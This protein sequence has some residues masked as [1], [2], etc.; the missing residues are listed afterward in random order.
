MR[1]FLNIIKRDLLL[2]FKQSSRIVSLLMFFVISVALFPFGVGSDIDLLAKI[3]VGV[4]WVCALLSS[5]V[6]ISTIFEDDYNDGSLQQFILTG[7][8]KET[9]VIAKI[10]AH[11]LTSGISI[12]LITPFLAVLMN[13]PDSSFLPLVLTLTVGTFYLSIISTFGASLTLGMKNASAALGLIN[14]PLYIPV[15]IFGVGSV[16]AEPSEFL[17]NFAILTGITLFMLP[18]CIFASVAAIENSN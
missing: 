11:W 3:S 18:V 16:Y 7:C 17:S 14:L 1:I 13:L 15:L 2:A 5:I 12:I 8:M 9:I 10:V 6:S 4:I